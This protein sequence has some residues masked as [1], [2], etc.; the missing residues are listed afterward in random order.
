MKLAL[1]TVQFGLPYGISNQQG[2]V[3]MAEVEKILELA[4]KHHIRVLDSAFAYGNS[5]QV[6]GKLLTKKPEFA[7][8]L[9]GKIP[10]LAE[11]EHDI[12][13]YFEQSLT[14]LKQQ[15]LYGL[16]LHN[17]NDLTDQTYQ[18]LVALKQQ[19]KV[20]K[21]GVSVYDPQLTD[22]LIKQFAL[23]LVQL[24]L[25]LFDQR[26]IHSGC[27]QRL[28]QH[29]IEVH[30]RSLFLQG[31]LLMPPT[32]LGQY[33][34]PFLPLFHQLQQ[35]CQQHKISIQIAALSLIHQTPWV[36]KAVIGVCSAQQLGEVIN[37]YHQAEHCNL[38]L[39]QF[40]CT[41]PKLLNPSF[42]P[43]R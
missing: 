27:L 38:E 16:L 9:V 25:N 20:S 19:G 31:L 37:A 11:A 12:S 23:D 22:A 32:Q 10:A 4:N 28:K 3:P 26:F 40:A 13:A 6:L 24:P 21:I 15:R 17:A 30:V 7:F 5:E 36:D 1:G 8:E 33:F 41:Q 39:T 42:W 43:S 18:Q 2:Q 34:Q 29:K 14:Q 35:A